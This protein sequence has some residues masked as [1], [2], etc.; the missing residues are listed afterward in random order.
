MVEKISDYI[1]SLVIL[2]L[3]MTIIEL[4]LPN[5]KNKKYVMFVCSLVLFLSMIR[6]VVNILGNG[7]DVDAKVEEFQK[8]MANL[9]YQSAKKTS[10][11]ENIYDAYVMQLEKDMKQRMEEMGYRVLASEIQ[12]DKT[13]YEPFQIEMQIEYQ[14][15]EIQP[16][17]IDVFGDS[18]SLA[19]LYEADR[20]KV[21]Q[22]LSET[23]GVETEKIKVNEK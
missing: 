11:E 12:I 10:L 5:Q 6:P 14:D 20:N 9:E 18:S 13:T 1:A 19:P 2:L 15:G 3:A 8:E 21:K 22:I 17:V 7:V 4:I 23:Y 16:I